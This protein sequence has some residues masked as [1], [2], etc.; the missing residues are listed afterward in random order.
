MSIVATI[1]LV[2]GLSVAGCCPSF[3][4]TLKEL[5]ERVIPAPPPPNYYEEFLTILKKMEDHNPDP[6]KKE[7]CPEPKPSSPTEESLPS[8]TADCRELRTMVPNEDEIKQA[9]Q[10]VDDFKNAEPKESLAVSVSLI[11]VSSSEVLPS[12]TPKEWAKKNLALSE[13]ATFEDIRFEDIR[14]ERKRVR[15]LFDATFPKIAENSKGL[16]DICNDV[17]GSQP[18]YWSLACKVVTQAENANA[19]KKLQQHEWKTLPFFS[20]NDVLR[21]KYLLEVAKEAIKLQMIEDKPNATVLGK[22]CL[23]AKKKEVIQSGIAYEMNE[24]NKG[25]ADVKKMTEAVLKFVGE[26]KTIAKCR[27]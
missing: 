24:A 19:D 27:P 23:L 17:H 7:D 21:V 6:N 3:F 25:D 5:K 18:P 12:K 16:G 10:D 9:V 26:V 1:A 22:L 4:S 20:H 14:L 11:F 15:E 8:L 13:K 2:V